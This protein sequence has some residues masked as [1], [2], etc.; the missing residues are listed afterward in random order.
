MGFGQC[1]STTLPL[2]T[3]GP[4]N[5]HFQPKIALESAS[6]PPPEGC[7]PWASTPAHQGL[8]K[9]AWGGGWGHGQS[10]ARGG[11]TDA[12]RLVH[13][14]TPNPKDDPVPDSI[15]PDQG[16]LKAP[17]GRGRGRG[18]VGATPGSGTG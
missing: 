17:P 8:K 7:L 13:E 18:R 11:P 1:C 3:P 6:D 9:E 16:F 14:G 10:N 4:E 2:K 15:S 12:C 5:G